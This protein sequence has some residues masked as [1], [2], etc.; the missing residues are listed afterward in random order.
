L[1]LSITNPYRIVEGLS[2]EKR[3]GIE[4]HINQGLGQPVRE[5]RSCLGGLPD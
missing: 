4:F 3:T 2:P 5:G 1:R